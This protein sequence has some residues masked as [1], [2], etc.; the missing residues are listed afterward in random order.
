MS[1][2]PLFAKWSADLGIVG[3][4]SYH[5]QHAVRSGSHRGHQVEAHFSTVN[6]LSACHPA[7]QRIVYSFE[8]GQGVT[9][10]VRRLLANNDSI[11]QTLV[12]ANVRDPGAKQRNTECINA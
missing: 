4:S 8:G 10:P 7:G 1:V 6:P 5:G 9:L 2:E 11:S 3:C 12:S